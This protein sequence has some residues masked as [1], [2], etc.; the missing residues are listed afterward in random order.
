[1]AH[2]LL[3][4]AAS[5]LMYD[6]LAPHKIPGGACARKECT[7]WSKLNA[8]IDAF[9]ARGGPVEGAGALCAQLARSPGYRQLGTLDPKKLGGAGAFCF[10]DGGAAVGYCDS[11]TR[12]IPEQLNVQ[13]AAPD[14]L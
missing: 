5:G 12:G 7:P 9:W 11:Q 3:F 13:I 2:V 6:V 4:V 10:C 1:M 8:T 14:H